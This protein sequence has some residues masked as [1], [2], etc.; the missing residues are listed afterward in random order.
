MSLK[1]LPRHP[2]LILGGTRSGKSAYAEHL[3]SQFPPPY[4]YIATAQILD[5]EMLG[6]VHRHQERRKS[7]W[8]TLE[9]PFQL[10]ETLRSLQGESK[11][12]LVD[13]ITLWLTNLLLHP[14]PA[15]YEKSIRELCQWIPKAD[16]PLFLVSNEVGGGI[17]PE[18]PLARQF[19]D[20]AGYANQQIAA[21]CSAVTLV[22]A[23]L[24]LAL[25]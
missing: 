15:P 23:G 22:V 25:K 10:L 12:V 5:D 1:T 14:S 21:T 9:S 8:E 3:V 11:V 2:H 7:S 6:R 16:Y 24:P 4:V 20:L 17:V 13:C 19:R 18:N